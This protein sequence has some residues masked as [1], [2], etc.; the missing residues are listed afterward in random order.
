MIR[1]SKAN[2]LFLQETKCEEWSHDMLEKLWDS[3]IHD[4][5]AVDSI[6][7]SG[8]LLIS[9]NKQ[10]FNLSPVES[11][12]YWLW[13]KGS[14]NSGDNFNIVNVY[15]PH[16]IEGKQRFWNDLEYIHNLIDEEPLCLMGDFNSIR[17]KEDRVNC[18]YKRRDTVSF[19]DFVA[20]TGL[21]E[22]QGA[23]FSFTWF[24]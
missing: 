4:W 2:I 13:C 14:T 12:Q 6:G 10:L 3:D 20:V 8:G 24:G 15:G 11:S 21:I 7:A 19:N 1:D 22:L 9:W 16:D 23:N 5:Q 17:C 18:N